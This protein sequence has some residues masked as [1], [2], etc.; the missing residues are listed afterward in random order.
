[1]SGSDAIVGTCD[2]CGLQVTDGAECPDCGA[3]ILWPDVV[4]RWIR[5]RSDDPAEGMSTQQA[6]ATL[7][8]LNARGLLSDRE[9]AKAKQRILE[10]NT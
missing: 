4:E 2:G 9:Y 1:M 3:A 6:L 5:R 10:A 8:A 7:D